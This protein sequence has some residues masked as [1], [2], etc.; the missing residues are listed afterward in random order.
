[1][2]ARTLMVVVA[3]AAFG[4]TACSSSSK[5]STTATTASTAA[6]SAS[7]TTTS[8]SPT[9]NAPKSYSGASARFCGYAEK[10]S[11]VYKRTGDSTGELKSIYSDVLPA[12]QRTQSAAPDALKHDFEVFV[13]GYTE[14]VHTLAAINFDATKL[15]PSTFGPLAT[16]QVKAASAHI[17]AYVTQVCHVTTTT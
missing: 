7:P 3:L 15:T 14:V 4:A 17:R 8:G 11:T 2:R 1:M 10:D 16:P 9:T 6:P 12:L 13:A 5:P